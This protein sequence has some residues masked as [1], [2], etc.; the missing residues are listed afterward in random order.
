MKDYKQYRPIVGELQHILA[1]NQIQP[2]M[3]VVLWGELASIAPNSKFGIDCE[4]MQRRWISLI[5]REYK[6]VR[7]M[8]KDGYLSDNMRQRYKYILEEDKE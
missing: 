4:E 5:K 6:L 8:R 3:Q 2:E 1:N 7:Q